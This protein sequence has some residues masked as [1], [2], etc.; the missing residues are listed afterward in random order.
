MVAEGAVVLPGAEIVEV[1]IPGAIVKIGVVDVSP[2]N[3]TL[4]VFSESVGLIVAVMVRFVT[5]SS[6]VFFTGVFVLVYVALRAKGVSVEVP[7]ANLLTIFV[8][9]LQAVVDHARRT[10][11][12]SITEQRLRMIRWLTLLLA[13][14]FGGEI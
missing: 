7:P 3:T 12:I 5:S 11:M 14:F 10:K 13:V 2:V 6:P 4:L 1:L 8:F 9:E